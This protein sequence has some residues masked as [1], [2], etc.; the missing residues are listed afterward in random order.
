MTNNNF[1]INYPLVG[2]NDANVNHNQQNLTLIPQYQTYSL[3][4]FLSSEINPIYH[5]QYNI[6]TPPSL[7]NNIFNLVYDENIQNITSYPNY[8]TDQHFKNYYS[9]LILYD[10]YLKETAEKLI[11]QMREKEKTNINNLGN[12]NNF[13]YLGRKKAR[14][15][16]LNGL[17]QENRPK[18]NLFKVTTVLDKRKEG[19]EGNEMIDENYKT[20]STE[21]NTKEDSKISL[22]T[23]NEQNQPQ[24][25]KIETMQKKSENLKEI[26]ILQVKETLPIP[27]TH[28]VKEEKKKV[29]QEDFIKSEISIVIN[30]SDINENLIVI[31]NK[32]EKNFNKIKIKRKLKIKK[33]NLK[34]KE[35]EKIKSV[36]FY[37]SK[38]LYHGDDYK[39]TLSTKDF[40]KYNFDFET[41]KILKKYENIKKNKFI[42]IPIIDFI[43]K[44]N[45]DD[46]ADLK[47]KWLK[48]RYLGSCNELKKQINDIEKFIKSGNRNEVTEEDCLEFLASND[49][50]GEK[51]TKFY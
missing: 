37:K 16:D 18:F 50:M 43:K 27:F 34:K 4:S 46:L 30:N 21:R 13:D 7:N 28:L 25:K 14:F 35:K 24:E 20:L 19:H 47:P 23:K 32:R 49:Y 17:T 41:P 1:P 12:I 42:E 29:S 26:Q 33:K 8:S 40:M 15:S 22:D 36:S 11:S 51:L 44:K 6:Q 3:L 48:S 2:F 31:Q 5:Q 38:C 10:Q 9:S 39:E 45:F